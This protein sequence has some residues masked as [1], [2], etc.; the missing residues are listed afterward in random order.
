M[1]TTEIQNNNTEKN[2]IIRLAAYCR[3]SSNSEDQLNSFASQIQYYKNYEKTH[4]EYYLVD[5]Y[6]DEGIT[7]TSTDKRDEFN[8]LILDCKKGKIDRIIAKSVSRFSRN[9]NELLITL[10]I[11]KELEVSV[12][13][14]EQGIDT[15]KMNMEMIVTFPGMAAQQESVT[16][17]ENVRW[18]Y[19]KRMQSGEYIPRNPAY[20]FNLVNGKLEINEDEANIIRRIF[21]LYLNGYGLQ[22]ITQNLNDS[23]VLNRKGKQWHQMSIKYILSNERY[24]GDALLQKNYTTDTVPFLEVK[25]K[26]ERPQYYV[27]NSNPAIVSKETYN[28]V[29]LLRKQRAEQSYHKKN[30]YPLSNM[31]HCPYCGNSF[32]RLVTRNKAYWL[33]AS[34][35]SGKTECKSIRLREIYV[36]ETFTN[37]MWKLKKYQKELI[38]NFIHQLEIVKSRNSQLQEQIRTIDKSIADFSAQNFII[39]KL[40]TKGILNISDYTLKASDINEKISKLRQ[41]RRKLLSEDEND[42]ILET[43]K[44]LN[45]LIDNYES[46]T[47]FDNE[48]F[49]EIVKSITAV[50]NSKITFNLIGG[51]KLTEEISEEG[52]CKSK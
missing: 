49:N 8:R 39:T 3:V 47:D 41:R 33:C 20:G 6:A 27:E 13:F 11:L 21:N 43:V 50:D 32:R 7:G 25:N 16:L 52:R 34:K 31:I 38:E 24:M 45:Y 2:K 5:I 36:Y 44:Y 18:S 26:G 9:T 1:N 22:R 46:S 17:S 35:A 51:I 10:R 40:H 29:Q 37:M 19:Q 4:P 15:D 28:T 14:E 42:E 30:A 12:Y 23:G 48:L